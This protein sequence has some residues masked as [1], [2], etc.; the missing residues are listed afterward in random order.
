MAIAKRFGPPLVVLLAMPLILLGRECRTG[1]VELVFSGTSTDA[2]VSVSVISSRYRMLLWKGTPNR[3]RTIS[4]Q[5][6]DEGSFE[7]A[8]VWKDGRAETVKLGY[9]SSDD[10][11]H[12]ITLT[13]DD[14]SLNHRHVGLAELAYEMSSCF[15]AALFSEILGYFAKTFKNGGN[16]T[17]RP[18]SCRSPCLA[19]HD[20][21]QEVPDR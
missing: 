15:D 19:D 6:W 12:I 13:D 7:I 10:F 5:F 17:Q 4:F 1:K 20:R 14:I 18:A 21:R 11:G 3:Q 9:V 8:R 2:R 16:K